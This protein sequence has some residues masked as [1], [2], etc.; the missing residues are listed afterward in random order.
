MT[1]SENETAIARRK[2]KIIA[3]IETALNCI[4][5][6][7]AESIPIEHR[8]RIRESANQQLA[9]MVRKLRRRI[10]ADEIEDLGIVA[11]K[12]ESPI[13]RLVGSAQVQC[14]RRRRSE[15]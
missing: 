11:S 5:D 9:A 1:T 7:I 3:E 15:C 13:T 2:A 4:P 6:R 10:G 12:I 14:Q 8:E